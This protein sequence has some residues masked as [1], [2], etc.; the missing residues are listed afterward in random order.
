MSIQALTKITFLGNR[1]NLIVAEVCCG[2]Q[3]RFDREWSVVVS[4]DCTK[5]NHSIDAR[6]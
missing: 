5:K 3:L 2:E 6:F 4:T 1:N